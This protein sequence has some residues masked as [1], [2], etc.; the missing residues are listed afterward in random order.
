MDADAKKKIA[1][2]MIPNGIYVLTGG[3]REGNAGAAILDMKD[4]GHNVYYSG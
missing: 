3:G 1:I 2:R 4:L